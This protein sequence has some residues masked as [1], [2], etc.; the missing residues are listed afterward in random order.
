[1]ADLHARVTAN[2]PVPDS[3]DGYTPDLDKSK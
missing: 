2:P 1:M 3:Y